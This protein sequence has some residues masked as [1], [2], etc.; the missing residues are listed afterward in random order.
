ML[1][2][3]GVFNIYKNILKEISAKIY[4]Q[5]SIRSFKD[6]AITASTPPQHLH[7]IYASDTET[8]RFLTEV[9]FC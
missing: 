6:A 3:D 5:I 8:R 1:I 7:V 4:I 2:S 9:R